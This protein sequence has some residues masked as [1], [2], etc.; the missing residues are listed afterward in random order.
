MLYSCTCRPL[1]VDW[2][3]LPLKVNFFLFYLCFILML[4]GF[5]AQQSPV[6]AISWIREEHVR[7]GCHAWLRFCLW[8]WSCWWFF[9]SGA[10]IACVPRPIT[11]VFDLVRCV[12]ICRSWDSIPRP[13]GDLVKRERTF[14]TVQLIV[15][16]DGLS[17]CLLTWTP[18]V[19]DFVCGMRLRQMST[20]TDAFCWLYI[21]RQS[22]VDLQYI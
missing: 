13:L 19:Q 18:Y 5:P 14:P 22:T 8:N 3:L 16:Y 20:A 11:F 10:P 2:L 1:A 12:K 7:F 9:F 6:L 21:A 17:V 4:T 15:R